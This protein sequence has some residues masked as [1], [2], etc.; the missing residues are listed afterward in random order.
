[1]DN[2]Y[3]IKEEDLKRLLFDSIELRYL[4]IN[5]VDNWCGY[6]VVDSMEE[7]ISE[8]TGMSIEKIKNE[9][10]TF[11]A[12]VDEDIKKYKKIDKDILSEKEA[13]DCINKKSEKK[14]TC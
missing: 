3:L 11:D 1:M 12:I 7:Y 13:K 9:E 5:G 8:I 6:Y 14:L 2:Y 4:Y 10:I